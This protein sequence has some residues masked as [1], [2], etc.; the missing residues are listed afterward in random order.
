MVATVA[1]W[2]DTSVELFA[3]L[4]EG[5]RH[6]Y[7]TEQ[8]GSIELDADWDDIAE[9]H[10]KGK[11]DPIGVYPIDPE[12]GECKWGC[13]DFD[14]GEEISLIHAKNVATMLDLE[15]VTAWTERSRS[16]GYHVWVFA[17]EWMPAEVMRYALLYA[18]DFMGAPMKEI[19]P[20][21]TVLNDG[22]VGN[23]VRLPYPAAFGQ[24]TEYVRRQMVNGVGALIALANFTRSA[25]EN[26]T[27][28]E[29]LAKLANR[30]VPPPRPRLRA[31]A[32]LEI[33]EEEPDAD[34]LLLLP[35]EAQRLF[36]DGSRFEDRSAALCYLAGLIVRRN[37]NIG[38]DDTRQL[39]AY[40]DAR[41]GKYSDRTDRD[42]RLD[43]IV[44]R[45]YLDNGTFY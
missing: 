8:G 13:I 17:K 3:A 31:I 38:E 37:P 44:Q 1:V 35:R 6:R 41:W 30:W 11:I 39:L 23:Y 15:G 14:E 20:K 4:F 42:V 27:P 34:L 21:Q 32:P 16:K 40:A 33:V 5:N 25:W 10:L 22:E 28:V 43:E 36:L 26:R 45:A 18:C 7:G 19:N 24:E 9:L 29:T 2:D 12:T